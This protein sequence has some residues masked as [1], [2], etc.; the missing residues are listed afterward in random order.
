MVKKSK[1]HVSDAVYAKKAIKKDNPFAS[2]IPATSKRLNPFEVHMNKEKFQ[3]L[4]R[5][6]KHD[7]GLPG[8]SRAKAVKRRQDTLGQEYFDKHKTNKFK[9]RRIGKHLSVDQ[10]DEQ[11]MNARFMA[12]KMERIKLSKQSRFNL[13]DDEILTHRGQTL[14]EI[15]QF[16]DERS[17][18]ET[19]DEGLDERKERLEQMEQQRMTRMRADGEEDE[20]AQ[21][22]I[23][24]QLMI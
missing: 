2:A 23:T 19:E 18:D 10:I 14:E 6:C 16:R 11:I 21:N 8:V 17:D 4:G 1:K 12:D 13:N 22:Q 20:G 9:D 24:D 15:E 5:T 3:I 7:R